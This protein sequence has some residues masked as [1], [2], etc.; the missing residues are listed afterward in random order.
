MASGSHTG[1]QTVQ[2]GLCRETVIFYFYHS[3]YLEYKFT[4]LV[5]FQCLFRDVNFSHRD[6][7]LLSLFPGSVIFGKE[8]ER[9]LHNLVGGHP[10]STAFDFSQYRGYTRISE[11]PTSRR[12]GYRVSIGGTRE[13]QNI[14]EQEAGV[15]ESV[16]GPH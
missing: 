9:L 7:Q 11:C 8:Q 14:L 10:G 4:T 12:Q 1:P 3:K 6:T 5:F 13:L 2:E 16:S 15:I